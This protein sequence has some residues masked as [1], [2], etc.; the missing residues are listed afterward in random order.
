MVYGLEECRVNNALLRSCFIIADI[1]RQKVK[2]TKLKEIIEED[3]GKK[4]IGD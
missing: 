1:L 4:V 2:N 3:K